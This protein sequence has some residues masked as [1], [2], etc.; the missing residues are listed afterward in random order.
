MIW[1]FITVAFIF[2]VVNPGFRRVALWIGGITLA[3]FIVLMIRAS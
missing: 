2:F 1:L 3:L